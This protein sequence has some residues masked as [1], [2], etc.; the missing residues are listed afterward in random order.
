MGSPSECSSHVACTERFALARLRSLP[1]SA[2]SRAPA[3]RSPRPKRKACPV[4]GLNALELH[5]AFPDYSACA[6]N[7]RADPTW[8]TGSGKGSMGIPA[9]AI[10]SFSRVTHGTRGSAV[11]GMLLPLE[12]TDT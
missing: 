10:G 5:G 7:L 3:G 12:A 4:R 11:R 8:S 1:L 2:V 6:S 9:S